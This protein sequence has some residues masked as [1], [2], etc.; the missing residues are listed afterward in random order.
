VSA[1]ARVRRATG[2]DAGALAEIYGHHVL[3]G[4]ATFE[5]EPPDAAEMDRRRRAIE[6]SGL[7]YLVVEVGGVVRGYAY[8]SRFRPRIGYRFTVEDSVY[9]RRECMGRGLGRLLLGRLIEDCEGLGLR[10]MVAVVGDSANAASIRLHEGFGFR[11][12]GVLERVGWK[13]ERWFD[14]VLMQRELGE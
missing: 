9:I 3:T 10:Q 4:A 1:G 11:R 8:A 13:F 2:E 12:V 6:D 5:L 14:A 7:P